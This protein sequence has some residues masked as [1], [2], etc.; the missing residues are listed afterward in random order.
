LKRL[1]AKIL[2]RGNKIVRKII[3][4]ILISILLTGCGVCNLNSFILPDDEEFLAVIEELDTPQKIGDY[5][6]ENFTCEAH[7]FY[8]PDPYTLWKTK[9][10]DCNDMAT[11][12]VFVANYHGYTTYQIHIYYQKTL[13]SHYLAVYR[14]N[15]KYSFT[16]NQYYYYGFDTFRDIVEESGKH[17]GLIW[18]KYI[19]YDYNNDIIEEEYNN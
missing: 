10:G 14:E 16:D 3:L 15:N 9:K 1:L 18:T 6:L 7:I 11:F 17:T 5:M 13:I 8:A 19:V 2:K 12:G 4:L